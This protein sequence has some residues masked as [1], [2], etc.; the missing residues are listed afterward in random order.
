MTREFIP[1]EETVAE[2]R[3]DPEYV[4]AY[5]SLEEEFA[6]AEALI[7]ARG[8]AHMTQEQVAKAMG[9]TQKAV[10]RLESGRSMPSTRTLK[11][12]AEATGTRLRISFE[13]PR[14]VPAPAR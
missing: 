8:A 13:R 3:G 2:W 5:D 7:E 10:A 1:I 14:T 9:V 12:Y 6:L 4:A 11:R